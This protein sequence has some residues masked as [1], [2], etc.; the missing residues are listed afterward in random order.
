MS[1]AIEA[2]AW[3]AARMGEAIRV[4]ARAGGIAV[5]DVDVPAAAVAVSHG[6]EAGLARTVARFAEWLGVEAEPTGASAGDVERLVRGVAPALV[7]VPGGGAPRVLVLVPARFGA[8]RVVDPHGRVHRVRVADLRDLL[9]RELEAPVAAEVSAILDAAQVPESRRGRA[10]RAILAERLS[11][12]RVEGIFMLRLPATARLRTQLAHARVP[13]RAARLFAAHLLEQALFVASFWLLGVTALSGNVDFGWLAAWALMLACQAPLHSYTTRAQASM[14]IDVAALLRRHLLAGALRQNADLARQEGAGQTLGRVLESEAI[15]DMAIGAGFAAALASAELLVG[16]VILAMG[17]S[18]AIELALLAAFVAGAG[19]LGMRLYRARAAWTDERLA[20]THDTIERM[21]GHRTR[22]AQ[23]AKESWHDGEDPALSRMF[24]RGRAMD[25]LAVAL[26][27]GLPRGWLLAS[28][29]ALAPAMVAGPRAGAALAVSIGGALVVQRALRRVS[30][31]VV[32]LAGAR[33]SW[34]RLQPIFEAA[35]RVEAVAT[36]LALGEPGAASEPA[37][38]V[39]EARHVGFHHR[40][41]SNP[42][43]CDASLRVSSG[44]RVL[45]EG[46]SG[47]GKSTLAAIFDRPAGRR[48]RPRAARRPRSPY[49]RRGRVARARRR[50]FRGFTTTTSSAPRWPST[51][52]WVADGR[53]R[54]AT[55][56]RPRRCAASCP[57]ALSST[58]CR[59]GFNSRWARRGGSCR[60]ASG[61]ASSWPA[62]SC[63]ALTWWCSTRASRRSNPLTLRQ[64]VE[65]VGARAGATVVIAHP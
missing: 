58:G 16:A 41:R 61:V 53:R 12:L 28:I 46:P 27:A 17:G 13:A 64:A 11:A 63:R 31:G 24:D 32:G 36:P 38:V 56:R 37:R 49:A 54:T 33:V 42:V 10:R 5:R 8:P 60:T 47:C 59:A 9:C 6:D 57:S 44:D 43:L 39:L 40:G 30:Q 52:S 51:C 18:A 26:A 55:S 25:R 15:E 62:R 35:T 20:L 45:V 7:R 21:V 48:R 19:F 2:L 50:E 34:R 1:A 4:A 22:L 65:C 29:A 14:A 23:E 3:P